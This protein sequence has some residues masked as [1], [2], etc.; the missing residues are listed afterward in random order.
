[1]GHDLPSP[2]ANECAATQRGARL[3]HAG[4]SRQSRAPPTRFHAGP[5]LLPA[6]WARAWALSLATSGLEN[7]SLFWAPFCV[8][9]T[10]A[11]LYNQIRHVPVLGAQKGAQIGNAKSEQKRV[12]G[13]RDRWDLVGQA[14]PSCRQSSLARSDAPAQADSCQGCPVAACAGR[15][16][17][18]QARRQAREMRLGQAQA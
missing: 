17:G 18:P 12:H 10:G 1:M 2:L 9:K 5:C 3:V 4:A 8:P 6:F 14:A 13:L 11:P 15:R 7:A 16:L